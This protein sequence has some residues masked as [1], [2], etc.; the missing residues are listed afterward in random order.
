M[1]SQQWPTPRRHGLEVQ[2]DTE[3]QERTT[4]NIPLLTIVLIVG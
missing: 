3:K 4:I 2:A 1:L